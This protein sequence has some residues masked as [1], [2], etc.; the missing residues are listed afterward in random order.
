M[1]LYVK[2]LIMRGQGIHEDELQAILNYLTTM[3]EVY[4]TSL[5]SKRYIWCINAFSTLEFIQN[6]KYY[7]VLGSIYVT[8]HMYIE[9]I[10]FSN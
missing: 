9:G 4:S 1:L 7:V 5:L 2:Q 3:H 10:F 6:T 8:P